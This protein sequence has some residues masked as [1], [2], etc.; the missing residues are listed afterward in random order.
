MGFE[1]ADLW[2]DLSHQNVTDETMGFLVDLA[3]QRQVVGTL[4]RTLIGDTV[5]STE[6]RP[7]VHGAMRSPQ[8]VAQGLAEVETGRATFD[9]MAA[10]A[11]EI[12]DGEARGATGRTVEA[13]V[14][15]GIGGSHLGPALA[16]DALRHLTHPGVEVRFS[17]GIDPDDLDAW[18]RVGRELSPLHHV[19]AD[20]PPVLIIHGDDD[21]VV[22]FQQSEWYIEAAEK[23]GATAKLIRKRGKGHGWAT[24]L[25]DIRKFA[26]WFDK[27]LKPPTAN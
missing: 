14:H 8:A 1:C 7:A 5:N 23:H 25:W 19:A 3:T 4:Q 11:S 17:S 21:E 9:R 10:L 15:L 6:G 27:H 22:S 26:K 20:T 2:I 16:V 18:N 24:I 12:R 13:V